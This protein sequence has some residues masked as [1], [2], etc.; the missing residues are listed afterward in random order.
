MLT[1]L[2]L[3]AHLAAPAQDAPPQP[4]VQPEEKKICRVAAVTSTRTRGT[5]V[6]KTRAEWEATAET[7]RQSNRFG[8]GTDVAR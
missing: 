5:R 4:V 8:S 2:L 3:A 7:M 6:C 1:S